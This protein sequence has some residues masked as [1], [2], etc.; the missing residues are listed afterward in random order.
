KKELYQTDRVFI[1]D[2][3]M[4]DKNQ[5]KI[6]YGLKGFTGIEINVKGPDQDLHSGLYGGAVRNPL[7]A[8]AHILSSMKN[9]DEVVLVDGFYDGV[10]DLTEEKRALIASVKDE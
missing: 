2:S 7:M 6:L 4:F 5:P 10:E 1:S 3:G 9:E 8:L